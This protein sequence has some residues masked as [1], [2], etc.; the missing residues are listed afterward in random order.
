MIDRRQALIGSLAL[1]FAR[2]RSIQCGSERWGLLAGANE[3]EK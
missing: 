2:V 3:P 1:S